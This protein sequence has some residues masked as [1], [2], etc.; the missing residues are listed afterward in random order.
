[1]TDSHLDEK[2]SPIESSPPTGS[3]SSRSSLPD[4]DKKEKWR[5]YSTAPTS[6]G[7]LGFSLFEKSRTAEDN[8]YT[9]TRPHTHTALGG[10]LKLRAREDDDPTSWWFASTAI[11]LIVATFAPMANM[12][13][14]AALVVSWRGTITQD[15]PALMYS[16][17]RPIPDPHWCL[18]LNGASLACGFVGNIFLLC[19]FTRKVRYIIALPVTIFLFYI[20]SGI[21]VGITV[22]MNNR[23]PILEGQVYS[24]GFW[25]A[26]IA[27]CL[28][29]LNA[30]LLMANMLGYFLGHYP[31]HFDLNDEQRNL[32]LQTMIFFIWLAGGAGVFAKVESLTYPDALYF[33][34]VTLLT[35]G[36]GDIYAQTDT[37]RGLVFPFSVGGTIILGLMVSSIHKFARELSKENVVKKH[38]ETRR[39]DTLSRA[40]SMPDLP[41]REFERG[42][43][44][45][46]TQISRPLEGEQI[47]HDLDEKAKLDKVMNR[48]I[49]F[50]S[51]TRRPVTP[52]EPTEAPF[53]RFQ[54]PHD[55]VS[56]SSSRSRPKTL[57]RVTTFM[58][59]MPALMPTKTQKAIL[60]ASEKDRFDKMRE[61]QYKAKSFRRWYALTMSVLSFSL[62]W[63]VGA[64]VFQAV[65]AETQGITY[66]Q[67]LYFCY[68][69]LLTIGYG[70]LSPKSNAG[71]AFFVVWSL[72]AVPTMTILISDLGETAIVS[73]KQKVLDYGGLAFLG[74][75]K[76]WNT[77]TLVDKKV[78]IQ[79]RLSAAGLTMDKSSKLEAGR[80]R[81]LDSSDGSD[82]PADDSRAPKTIQELA[83]EELDEPNMTRG[84]AYALRRVADDMKRDPHKHYQYEEWVEF[85]RYIRFSRLDKVIKDAE[86]RGKQLQ[87]DETVDGVIEWDWL[88]SNSPMT[89][90]QSEAEWVLDRLLESLL[91]VIRRKEVMEA[92]ATG[93]HHESFGPQR[94]RQS[95][96]MSIDAARRFSFAGVP[97]NVA[98]DGSVEGATTSALQEE[99]EEK[100]VWSKRGRQKLHFQRH[101]SQI[102]HHHKAHRKQGIA[103]SHKLKAKKTHQHLTHHEDHED[104][105]EMVATSSR[106]RTAGSDAV[107]PKAKV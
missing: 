46:H 92:L 61:I 26:V 4:V 22:G 76:G 19:N 51:P 97:P 105:T 69:S 24:Q 49:G 40:V 68:V 9:L 48:T 72:V 20:A 65:E 47:Q 42:N 90:E 6:R 21:L 87:Y 101:P 75:G 85:T 107:D 44:D 102:P 95:G 74:K 25:H 56:R 88:D 73:F 89:S 71:K 41:P 99:E 62:L 78:A 10:I 106:P 17:A 36:F 83:A 31:Q 14:I 43:I 100:P 104:G 84:L 55:D 59:H 39:L 98:V 15:T 2:P 33:C 53:T 57:G 7:S 8:E 60:M 91:R 5:A 23:D 77:D 81:T 13:S 38:I 11:P 86:Q 37:G 64:A 67:G 80:E 54:F 94:N 93:G 30:M 50:Q 63:C 12:L 34:D 79:R 28:Y 16:T 3:D 103:F 58:S 52:T 70:D 96:S 29:M 1:M 35:I 27:A 82:D 32:I 45:I 18:N 66:F